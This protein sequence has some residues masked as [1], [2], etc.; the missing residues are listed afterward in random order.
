M[1]AVGVIHLVFPRKH[2]LEAKSLQ[3]KNGRLERALMSSLHLSELAWGFFLY[4]PNKSFTFL[5]CLLG[6]L[7][8]AAELN[9]PLTHPFFSL[10]L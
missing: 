1:G 6:F 8:F 7:L 2:K 9:F 3:I 10:H 5:N 4:E